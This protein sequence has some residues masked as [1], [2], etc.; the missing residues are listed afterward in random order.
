MV[1]L[2]FVVVFRTVLLLVVVLVELLV[3]ALAT[4]LSMSL[5]VLYVDPLPS[6]VETWKDTVPSFFALLRS[7]GSVR[8]TPKVSPPANTLVETTD[9]ATTTQKHIN[10]LI[11][12]VLRLFIFNSPYNFV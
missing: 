2:W 4:L 10:S 11:L 6:V 7:R 5:Y 1:V 12:I 8:V 9:N 3:V